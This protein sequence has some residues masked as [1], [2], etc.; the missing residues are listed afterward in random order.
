[1]DDLKKISD[2]LSELSLLADEVQAS[3][4]EQPTAQEVIDWVQDFIDKEISTR[5]SIGSQEVHRQ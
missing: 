5:Q 2:L 4:G 3:T 1:M